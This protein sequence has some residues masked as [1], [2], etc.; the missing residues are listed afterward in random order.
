MVEPKRGARLGS[1]SVTNRVFT[2]YAQDFILLFESE[3]KRPVLWFWKDGAPAGEWVERSEKTVEYKQV[4]QRACWNLN[5][6]GVD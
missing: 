6:S 5:L 4:L 2:Y 3:L 1:Q